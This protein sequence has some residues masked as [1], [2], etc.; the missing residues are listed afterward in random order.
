MMMMMMM[1][2]IM[3]IVMMMMTEF[4]VHVIFQCFL[5]FCSSFASSLVLISHI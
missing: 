5:Q 4:E 1:M 2:M 3:M